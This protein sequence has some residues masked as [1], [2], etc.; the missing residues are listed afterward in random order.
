MKD[1]SVLPTGES[2]VSPA[3][4]SPLDSG[5]DVAVASILIEQPPSPHKLAILACM[6][7]GLIRR[8]D[9]DVTFTTAMRLAKIE[10]ER[11]NIGRMEFGAWEDAVRNLRDLIRRT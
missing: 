3:P 5:R 11:L 8:I 6:V 1:T 9:E 4:T 7:V 10:A 2:P